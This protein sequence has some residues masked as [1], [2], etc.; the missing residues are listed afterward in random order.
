MCQRQYSYLKRDESAAHRLL[1]NP[2]EVTSG[3][4]FGAEL[5]KQSN[6]ETT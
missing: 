3:R 4:A 6:R 1:I 2:I 5:I